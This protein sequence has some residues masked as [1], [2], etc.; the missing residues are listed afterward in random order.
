MSQIR[1]VDVVLPTRS[2]VEIRRCCI[3]QPTDHQAILLYHLGLHLPS[4]LP[5][6]EKKMS[7]L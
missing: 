6:A 7:Q 4:H 5:I 3:T 2:G 1:M